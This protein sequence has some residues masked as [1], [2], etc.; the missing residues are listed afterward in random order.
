MPPLIGTKGVASAQGFGWTVSAIRGVGGW[1]ARTQEDFGSSAFRI[2]G[3]S[4]NGIFFCGN[5]GSSQGG[6]IGLF[7]FAGTLTRQF[8]FA[9]VQ[10][11]VPPSGSTFM[12]VGLPSGVSYTGSSIGTGEFLIKLSSSNTYTN[13]WRVASPGQMPLNDIQRRA[14]GSAIVAGFVS[15]NFFVHV[16]DATLAS[17]DQS[18]LLSGSTVAN[19]CAGIALDSSENVIL[20]ASNTGNNHS[21]L[22]KIQNSSPFLRTFSWRKQLSSGGFLK[23]NSVVVNSSD[24]IYLLG[25]VTGSPAYAIV[26]KFNSSGVFQ[27]G[28]QLDINNT[29]TSL[30]NNRLLSLDS[31]GNLYVM[32]FGTASNAD[33]AIFKYNSSGTLQWQRQ[34]RTVS[35][36]QRLQPRG[37][38]V[39]GDY[40]YLACSLPLANNPFLWKLPTNGNGEGTYVITSPSYTFAYEASS[41]TDSSFSPIVNDVTQPTAN[42][43]SNTPQLLTPNSTNTSQDTWLR[44]VI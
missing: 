2:Y 33:T 12:T 44:T 7:S 28:R 14:N 19:Y 29:S 10:C 35:G 40:M 3:D 17:W 20:A 25:L 24:D 23:L 31:S 43:T 16:T 9:N 32:W 15:N 22:L 6:R 18:A 27:W 1:I 41:Y 4:T 37:I 21:L 38:Y 34:I 26:L 13:G 5:N 8:N 39:S 36:A 42:N 30:Q 11:C